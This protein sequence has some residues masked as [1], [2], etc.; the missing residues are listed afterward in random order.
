MTTVQTT[1]NSPAGQESNKM[2]IKTTKRNYL[3]TLQKR[4]GKNWRMIAETVFSKRS[5]AR[6]CAK[7]LRNIGGDYRVR[8]MVIAMQTR[9]ET[10]NAS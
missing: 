7:E 4:I 10:D 9:P 1:N 3:W 2:A 8:K 5:V 6:E